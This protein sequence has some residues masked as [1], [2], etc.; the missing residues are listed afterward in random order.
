MATS[1]RVFKEAVTLTYL[2]GY[3]MADG[4]ERRRHWGSQTVR[5]GVQVSTQGRREAGI[6]SLPGT[7]RGFLGYLQNWAHTGPGKCQKLKTG[8]SSWRQTTHDQQRNQA[9]V[10]I[11]PVD[12]LSQTEDPQNFPSFIWDWHKAIIGYV[13]FSI[14]AGVFF[15]L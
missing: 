6:C 15:V 14:I 8:K 10:T 11:D 3:G 7:W 13:L 1:Y 9:L 5:R 2:S 4:W 12:K